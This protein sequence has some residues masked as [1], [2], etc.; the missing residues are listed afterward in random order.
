M[1]TIAFRDGI[2]AA[3]SMCV[4]GDVLT[5]GK[6]VFRRQGHLIGLAGDYVDARRYVEAFKTKDTKDLSGNFDI[7][8]W[9]GKHL[10]EDDKRNNPI[11]MS[12]MPYYAIGTGAAVAF[13][14][15]CMGA[16]AKEA[17]AAAIMFDSNT[18]GRVVSLHLEKKVP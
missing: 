9:D 2:M 7:L 13:G 8:L 14:A 5:P 18:N 11:R 10:Y 1:T 17:V 12:R 4:A 3:D 15:M 16:T 6:K